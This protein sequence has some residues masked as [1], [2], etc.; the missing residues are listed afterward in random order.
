[1]SENIYVYFEEANNEVRLYNLTTNKYSRTTL[2][3]VYKLKAF[4]MGKGY[5]ATDKE[6]KRYATDFKEWIEDLKD[7]DIFKFNYLKDGSHKGAT[8]N[9]FK[10]LCHGEYQRFE[11]IDA[12]EYKWIESCSKSPLYYCKAGTYNCHG[13]DFKLQYPSIISYGSFE[14]PFKAGKETKITELTKLKLGYYK[15]HIISNDERFRK[16]FMFSKHNVYTNTSILFAMKCQKE[17]YNIDIKLSEDEINCYVYERDGII[18]GE[19]V[20]RTWFKVLSKLK[21]R[22]PKNGLIKTMASSLWGQL[23]R[24]NIIFRTEDQIIEEG[25]DAV[26]EYD[27]E[28]E[29]YVYEI[30][31]NRKREDVYHLV[32]CEQPYYLNIGRFKQFLL[33]YARTLTAKVAMKYID[34]VVRICVDNVTFNEEHDDVIFSNGTFNLLKEN[35]T[36]GLIDFKSAMVY[37]HFDNPKYTTKHYNTDDETDDEL[38]YDEIDDDNLFE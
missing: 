11:P 23:S 18:R 5:E 28:H 15:V 3:K 32:K 30:S 35:K 12:I 31:K 36:T 33:S 38:E 17:G 8:I 14:I 10:R 24:H 9:M 25:I 29:Y 27:P 13:Y 2:Q 34:D 16:I 26:L 4:A 37:K 1:M 6:L 20:F 19:Q 22:F 7:N 21:E